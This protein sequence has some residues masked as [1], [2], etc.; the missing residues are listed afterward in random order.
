MVVRKITI[1]NGV[2]YIPQSEQTQ[3]ILPERESK[4]NTKKNNAH[5]REQNK[6]LSTNNEKFVDNLVGGSFKPNKW[7][8]TKWC[9]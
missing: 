7:W 4:P 6:I 1:N 9:F 3:S 2:K 5:T 8:I